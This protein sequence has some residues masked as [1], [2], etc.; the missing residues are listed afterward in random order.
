MRAIRRD[1]C[2]RSILRIGVVLF[3]FF[4]ILHTSTLRQNRLKSNPSTWNRLNRNLR[5]S[6]S[7]P[8][9]LRFTPDREER[10][11]GISD[12]FGTA[13]RAG[14]S[15][16]FLF[17]LIARPSDILEIS[18]DF[19]TKAQRESLRKLGLH[20]PR[21]MAVNDVKDE[22]KGEILEWGT[23]GHSPESRK[24]YSKSWGAQVLRNWISTNGSDGTNPG[25]PGRFSPLETVG[26]RC[27]SV[28]E[29]EEAIARVIRWDTGGLGAYVKG[30]WGCAGRSAI[31]IPSKVGLTAAQ[32]SWLERTLSRH[33][34]VV[35]EP[36]FNRCMDFSTQLD[37]E[38][39]QIFNM[40]I[41]MQSVS[42]QGQYS[43]TI[44]GLPRD[45][46]SEIS[47]VFPDDIREYVE[48]SVGE[49]VG[50]ALIKSNYSGPVGVDGFVY[51]DADH[52][53]TI[54]PIVEIN[55]RHTMGR[56][57][58]ELARKIKISKSIP[59]GTPF[60]LWIAP[61][62]KI[63]LLT[64]A[65]PHFESSETPSGCIPLTPLTHPQTAKKSEKIMLSAA[66]L[67][68]EDALKDSGVLGAIRERLGRF[69]ETPGDSEG[70]LEITGDSERLSE[71]VR[72]SEGFS[73][74]EG[75]RERFSEISKGSED[76]GF[77]REEKDE[78][79]EFCR[80]I[81]ENPSLEAKLRTPSRCVW[82]SEGVW[83]GLDIQEPARDESIRLQHHCATKL[84]KLSALQDEENRAQVLRTFAHHELQAVEL[85]AWA[86]LN[87]PHVP[88]GLRKGWLQTLVEE[89]SH[90]KLYLQRL[91]ALNGS[92]ETGPPLSSYFWKQLPSIRSAERPEAA[93]LCAMG[94]TLEAANL[95]HTLKFK[96]A[97]TDVG[98]TQTA[99]ILQR[100]HDEEITHVRQA[101]VWL[102]R[103]EGMYQHTENVNSD[104]ELYEK[105]VVFPFE[106]HKARGRPMQ[107]SA[108]RKAG[109]SEEFI[110]A[111]DNAKRK[112]TPKP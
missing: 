52:R 83:E 82:D 34:A 6:K 86:I 75:H 47:R 91:H 85:F 35:V 31:R 103:L 39:S 13:K 32:K 107:K 25:I 49:I 101:N 67:L 3:S 41:T 100:V 98:D 110:N 55:P 108:R 87:F 63:S 60:A 70:L 8:R 23:I 53:L 46:F 21:V 9:L 73:E 99:E 58:L 112:P 57:S 68:G 19:P 26:R 24:L 93:F 104:V 54:R 18:G 11:G 78:M 94:L 15:L 12:G 48:K 79:Y 90:C 20:M 56:V 51:V 10:A 28:G 71:I 109:L 96:Q 81:L 30:D 74:V 1:V 2:P 111:V 65:P 5:I 105:Y 80:E 44:L 92:M 36:W 29:A 77:R 22:W 50:N 42:D 37:I 43:A 95:D 97:F 64:P 88:I 4:V 72:G 59:E 14:S 38:G 45:T 27:E 89:Q 69:S 40:G 102:K 7:K 84:P 33:G 16:E 106:S 76:S 66:L 17:G 62:H 61:A